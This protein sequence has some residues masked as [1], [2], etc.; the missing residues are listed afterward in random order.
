MNRTAILALLTILGLAA[1]APDREALKPDTILP[2]FQRALEEHYYFYPDTDYKYNLKEVYAEA[3]AS[4]SDYGDASADIEAVIQHIQASTTKE[5]ELSQYTQRF[6]DEALKRL[7]DQSS[8]YIDRRSLKL[9]EDDGRK[10]GTGIVIR[11][12][13][14]G[15]FRIVDVLEGSPAQRSEVKIGSHIESVDGEPVQGLSV[16]GLAARIRGPL[17]TEVKL[18]LDGRLYSLVRSQFPGPTPARN[19]WKING[20]KIL[21]VQ[22]RSG[23]KGAASDLK[24]TL[25]DSSD[26]AAL[27]LD[28]RKLN[29]GE[30][31]EVFR[32][33]DLL[34]REGDM[35]STRGRPG[36]EKVYQ[37]SEEL[38][39]EGPVY[40]LVSASASPFS[41]VLAAALRSS[42]NVILVGPPLKGNAFS[43]DSVPLGNGMLRITSGVICG[44]D[45]EPLFLK[46][47]P[48]DIATADYIP[49]VAPLSAPSEDDPGHQAVLQELQ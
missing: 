2:D 15:R 19:T 33:A 46:G 1:C 44:P 25:A 30:F 27:V 12:D 45:G 31:D 42:P 20:K 32:M 9:L 36:K 7:P 28:L 14:N 40:V 3:L 10:A 39:F 4:F 38:L 13:E 22:I 26:R 16:E 11:K 24:N 5:E 47:I 29:F 21:V 41:E 8:Y 35:G 34:V 23:L 48:T 49:R 43:A 37:A 18:T 6:M 17:D